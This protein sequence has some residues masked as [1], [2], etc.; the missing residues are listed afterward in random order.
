MAIHPT[1]II[2]SAA[3]IELSVDVGAY[4]VIDG[5]VKIAAG[6]RIHPHAYLTGWTEIGPRCEIHPFASVGHVPQDFHFGGEKTYCRIGAGTVIREYVSVHR[7]AQPESATVVGRDCFFLANSHVG[8]NCVIGDRVTLINGVCVGGHCQVGTGA[9]FS[10][11]S[12]THQFVRI[13]QYAMLGGGAQAVMD[14]PPFMTVVT[15]NTCC[16]VN[17]VGMRRGAFSREE[18][19]ELRQAYKLL[20]RSSLPVG[21]AVARLEAQVET[22]AGRALLDFL[23]APSRRGIGV[24]PHHVYRRSTA[25]HPA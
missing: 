13:G 1:A 14:V 19:A 7:G 4:A 22:Q 6:A 21:K 25:K 12:S 10:A 9:L 3:E 15:R 8:H 24:G 18:I 17:V 5:P 20:Y 16:G 23:H 2:D 11:L